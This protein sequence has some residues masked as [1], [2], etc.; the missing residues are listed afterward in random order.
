MARSAR[1]RIFRVVAVAALGGLAA[2]SGTRLGDVW[3]DP[4]YGGGPL[5]NVAVFVLGTDAGVRR[6]AEDEFVRRLPMKTR[7]LA[8]Y[9]LM[10]AAEQGDLDKVRARLRA[11]GFDGAIV[12]RLAGVEGGSPRAAGGPE[13]IPISYRTLGDY[14]AS[15][16]QETERAGDARPPSS[17]RIQTNVYAVASESLIWSGASRTFNP[18]ATREVAGD[19][20]KSVV[21]QLQ[22]A[23]ILSED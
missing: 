17:V 14:Y 20:A 18:E 12:A 1:I 22:K 19:V 6:L 16:Y 8:G 9:G 4:Q 23:G 3:Q 21:E 10:P 5:Q 11:S 7:G 13:R 15:T 2:C